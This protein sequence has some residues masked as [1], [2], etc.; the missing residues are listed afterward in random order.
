[1]EV[2][3][4][5]ARVELGEGVIATCRLQKKEAGKS[6][7]ASEKAADVSSLSA[8]LA[9]RWKQ[10]AA[11]SSEKELAKTGQVRSFRIAG[12]DASKK[13]IELELAS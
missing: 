4:D 8:M 3:G 2:S 5:R 11:D 1:V 9:Q 12:L 6:T 10:G 13:L 7:V